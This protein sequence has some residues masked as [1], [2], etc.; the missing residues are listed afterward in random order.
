MEDAYHSLYRLL[1]FGME[2]EVWEVTAPEVR[3]GGSKFCHFFCDNSGPASGV[4]EL[5]VTFL[6]SLSIAFAT[7]SVYLRGYNKGRWPTSPAR[8]HL[9]LLTVGAVICIN[10]IFSLHFN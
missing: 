9:M 1:G 3:A 6:L 5:I 4:T 7:L 2:G 10:S 8:W